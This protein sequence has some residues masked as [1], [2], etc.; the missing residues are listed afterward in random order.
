MIH[1]VQTLALFALAFLFS[2]ASSAETRN[3]A[4]RL[5]VMDFGAPSTD[6]I[7]IDSCQD[8]T[9]R[10]CTISVD[11]DCIAINGSKG[12][13]AL[14]DKASPPVERIRIS[15]STFRLGHGVVT[16]GSEATKVRDVIVQRIRVIG[17]TAPR[18]TNVLR[19]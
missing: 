1:H 4:L 17:P 8:V 6:C 7:D 12:P 5:S 13:L 19:F 14:E 9:V 2:V 16:L 10:G 11:E 18:R 3:P 15:D